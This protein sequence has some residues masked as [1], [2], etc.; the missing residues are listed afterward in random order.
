MLDERGDHAV[1]ARRAHDHVQPGCA[2]GGGAHGGQ[3][4]ERPAGVS[5]ICLHEAGLGGEVEE[6]VGD[7]EAEV[8]V[9]V[10]GGD[11]GAVLDGD[12]EGGDGGGGGEDL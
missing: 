12:G 4:G 1:R 3:H 8:V 9:G 10:G 11:G 6:R 2:G 5:V 7:G